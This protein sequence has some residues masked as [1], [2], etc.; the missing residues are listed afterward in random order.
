MKSRLQRLAPA[1]RRA[2][3]EAQEG[4]ARKNAEDA[5]Q[6]SERKAR[7][8][9][10]E[11][12]SIYDAAPVGLACLDRELRYVRVNQRLA[13]LNGI[14]AADHIGKTVREVVPDLAPFAEAMAA[15]VFQT[16]EAVLNAE[17][18]GATNATPGFKRTWMAHYHPMKDGRGTI[19]G[20]NVV[21]EEITERKRLEEELR[22]SQISLEHRYI[23]EMTILAEIGRVIGSTLEIDQVYERFA[24]ETRKLI[25]F[26]SLIV[27]LRKPPGDTLEVAYASGLHVAG[28][29]AGDLFPMQGSIAEVA[30][31]DRAGLIVQPRRDGDMVSRFPSLSVSVRAG[32]RSIMCV[33]LIARDTM[34][35]TL[36][37]RSKQ[38]DAYTEQD[39][40][41]AEKIGAQI[42]GA[43]A[44]AQLFADLRSAETS[45]REKEERFRKIF[46]EGPLGMI[47]SGRDFRFLRANT[48][49][50]RMMGYDEKELHAAQLQGDNPPGAYRKRPGQRGQT[51]AGSDPA[52]PDGKALCAKGW[53]DRLGIDDPQRHSQ[54]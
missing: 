46:D 35:G 34:I 39:L 5:R 27:N 14:L 19:I 44:N 8:Q 28:R 26:H 9:L 40:R 15:R 21:V 30:I 10:A 24:A 25:P 4:K 47:T 50:C 18:N 32:I 22:Q 29:R 54:R 11:I 49:F 42:A 41:L 17:F 6:E 3:A 13:D 43:I 33:P 45:L 52:L 48:A 31:R 51:P 2:L 20:I 16:G 12:Q 53:S 37:I 1:V 7:R 36:A 38:T 23:A